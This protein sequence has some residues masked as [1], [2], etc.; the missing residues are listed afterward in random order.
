MPVFFCNKLR[1]PLHALI[2]LRIFAADHFKQVVAAVVLI[3]VMFNQSFGKK[4]QMR[5]KTV[6]IHIFL[7]K[8]HMEKVFYNI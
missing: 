4:F 3:A 6:I 8:F 2:R 5:N 7:M 1:N